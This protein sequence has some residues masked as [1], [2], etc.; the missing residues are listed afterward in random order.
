MLLPELELRPREEMLQSTAMSWWT[1]AGILA[2][3][4]GL[5]P[6]GGLGLLALPI[7]W[8]RVCSVALWVTNQR[9]VLQR[10]ILIRHQ[11]EV[12]VHRVDTVTVAQGPIQRLIGIGD[13]QLSVEGTNRIQLV[14]L[15]EPAAVRAS[16]WRAQGRALR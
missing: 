6:I 7:A 14:G 3:G 9:I 8:W 15:L 1:Q 2:L 5:L 16:I 11:V 10:G 12:Q 13:L 4:V